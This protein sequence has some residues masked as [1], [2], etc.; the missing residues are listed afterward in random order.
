MTAVRVGFG[1][2][3]ITPP[4]GVELAGY[5]PYLRRRSTGVH[6]RLH[7]RAVAVDGP[8]GRW[9]LA[10]CDLLG[11]GAWLVDE[12]VTEV[13][14]ETGW[15]PEQ[16]ALHATHNHSGPATVEAV[17]W[18]EPDPLYLAQLPALIAQACLAAVAGL[19][20]ARLSHAEVPLGWFAHN[21][22]LPRRGLT[23]QNALAGTW[24]EPAP[25]RIDTTVKV[26]RFDRTRGELAGFL[27]YYSCHPV[28]CGEQVTLIN[29]DFP[30]AALCRLERRHG[31][32]GIFLQG[33]LG[34][35]NP[36]YAHGPPEESLAALRRFGGRFAA[37]VDR[38][39]ASATPAPAAPV[40]AA[41]EEL[42]YQLAPYDVDA[43]RRRRD[44][45]GATLRATPA[46][47]VATG[48]GFAGVVYN[49]L[50]ATLD[51]LRRGEPVRR[52][53]IVQGFRLGPVTL[54]GFNLEVFHG[55]KRRLQ[56]RLGDRCLVL[57][58]TNGWLGYAPTRDAFRPPADPYPA[59]QV[60]LIACHLPFPDGIE[61]QLV[62]AG[63][64]VHAQLSPQ[65]S[66][67]Q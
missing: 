10:S 65:R 24:Q 59:Y 41:R 33:A 67:R 42:A 23:N 32:P 45:A 55:I 12:V 22:M 57:S 40:A 34:D 11:L 17:G 46:D 2:V 20:E 27:A 38:G 3:D 44:E 37:A 49:S 35:I 31:A 8:G 15:G 5:G 53:V 50:T 64:T 56:R 58:T 14:S 48:K 62:A 54:L 6:H 29:S 19:A 39:I 66:E 47:H 26:L 4:V 21:R 28:V 43:L 16:V 7:A 18:G 61:D 36:L 30:G 63:L 9:V 60:P 1:K 25:D 13:A 52:P 51:R